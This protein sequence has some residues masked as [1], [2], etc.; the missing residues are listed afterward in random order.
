MVLS[1]PNICLWKLGHPLRLN[2]SERLQC[3]WLLLWMEQYVCLLQLLQKSKQ[4][5]RRVIIKKRRKFIKNA[6]ICHF[7]RC[8][9]AG[10]SVQVNN[11]KQRWSWI[12]LFWNRPKLIEK[13]QNCSFF[14]IKWPWLPDRWILVNKA[15]LLLL[16]VIKQTKIDWKSQNCNFFEWNDT[17]KP[18]SKKKGQNYKSF[19]N[20]W[21]G[22]KKQPQS[23]FTRP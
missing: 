21:L 14:E 1:C 9:D 5:K 8:N 7:L 19:K 10:N 18:D 12:R 16:F 13:S 3:C 6:I 11:S 20:Q 17:P 15:D 23:K 2:N 22:K 4:R